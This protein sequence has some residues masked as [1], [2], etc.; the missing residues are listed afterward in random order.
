[1][2]EKEMA[3]NM[4]K[5]KQKERKCNNGMVRRWKEEQRS[6][7]ELLYVVS[8]KISLKI[9]FNPPRKAGDVPRKLVSNDSK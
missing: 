5:Q 7:K 4:L 8:K 9:M 3:K 2:C 6:Q 1:M